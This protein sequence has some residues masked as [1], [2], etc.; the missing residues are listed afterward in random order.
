MVDLEAVL[1]ESEQQAKVSRDIWHRGD[2]DEAVLRRMIETHARLTGSKR[3]SEI[4]AKWPE[5]R[6]RFVKV[7]PK[8]YRRALAELAA[9]GKKVAA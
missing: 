4:L 1:P 3:A 2:T 8:E 5:Y 6:A 9:N 7:F